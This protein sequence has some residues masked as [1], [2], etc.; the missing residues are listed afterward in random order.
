MFVM[1]NGEQRLK[2]VD[3][4]VS[5]Y[6][7]YGDFED[8]SKQNY[9]YI[10]DGSQGK[11]VGTPSYMS[12][13]QCVGAPPSPLMD[14]YAIGCTFF[15]LVTGRTPYQGSNAAVVMMKHLQEPPPT[16]AG[17]AEVST[18]SSYLLKRCMAKNPRDR[19]ASYQQ[20]V[21][22]ATSALHSLSTRIPRPG[23]A[24]LVGAPTPTE[25]PV[26]L[27]PIPGPTTTAIQ[28]QV[29]VPES[30]TWKHPGS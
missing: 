7:D 28:P 23:M 11:S 2:I 5:T 18:G 27:P 15:H 25:T 13:E 1:V 20:L 26:V 12:P 9:Q 3:F 29:P 8:F 22:A 6:I 17:V 30:R 21:A 19:F 16:F 24:K 4:G 10:D 14:I